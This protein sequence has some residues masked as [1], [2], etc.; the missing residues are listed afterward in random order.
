M[1]LCYF[2]SLHLIKQISNYLLKHLLNKEFCQH[3]LQDPP[4]WNLRKVG[5]IVWKILVLI[6]H[7]IVSCFSHTEVWWNITLSKRQV[8]RLI[9]E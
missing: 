7:E 4:P 8:Y 3:H 1:I 6:E 2:I 5:P 9:V